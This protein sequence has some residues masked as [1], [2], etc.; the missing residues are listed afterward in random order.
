MSD[1]SCSNV[2]SDISPRAR[3]IKKRI[4]KWDNIKLKSFCTA[5]ENI[6]K[7]KRKRYGKTFA[8][9]TSDKGFISKILYSKSNDQDRGARSALVLGLVS[10]LGQITVA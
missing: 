6:S 4:N 7:M 3:D 9:D 5:K 10:L 1:I 8:N 2:F